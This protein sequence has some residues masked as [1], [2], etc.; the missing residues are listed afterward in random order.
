MSLFSLVTSYRIHLVQ[1]FHE[2]SGETCFIYPA[3]FHF[4]KCT[5]FF[6]LCAL[7]II[8]FSAWDAFAHWLPDTQ[9]SMFIHIPSLHPFTV[10]YTVIY[11]TNHSCI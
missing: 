8:I 11:N 4:Q 6:P 7:H 9:D 2:L 3:L 10:P 1:Y 5:M